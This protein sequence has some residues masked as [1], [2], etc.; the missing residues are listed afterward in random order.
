M[1]VGWICSI[2]QLSPREVESFAQRIHRA[3]LLVVAEIAEIVYV[4]AK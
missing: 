4:N 3:A 2:L 1:I